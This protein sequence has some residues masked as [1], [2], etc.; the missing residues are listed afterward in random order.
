VVKQGSL[1]ENEKTL[2]VLPPLSTNKHAALM[3]EA[4]A[5]M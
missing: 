4:Q 3:L 2:A 1:K 5:Q